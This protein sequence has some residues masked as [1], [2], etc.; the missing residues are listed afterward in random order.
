MLRN[1]FKNELLEAMKE[2]DTI[3]VSTLR[4]ILAAIKDRDL[5]SKRKGNGDQITDSNILDIL[6][7]MVKQRNETAKIYEKAG[8]NELAESEYKE[9]EVINTFMPKMLT[10]LELEKVIEESINIIDASINALEAGAVDLQ[11]YDDVSFGFADI[12]NLD[13]SRVQINDYVFPLSKGTSGQYLQIDGGGNLNFVDAG[14]TPPI[15]I[16]F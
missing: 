7:K 11:S 12:S 8:R 6:A 4:L 16:L 5:E 14:L 3:R 2:K 9:I 1:K 13:V 15:I 10:K